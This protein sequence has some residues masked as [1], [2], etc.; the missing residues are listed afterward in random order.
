MLQQYGW[1]NITGLTPHVSQRVDTQS[2]YDIQEVKIKYMKNLKS[3]F[4]HL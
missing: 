2:T 3:F 1:K 4:Y